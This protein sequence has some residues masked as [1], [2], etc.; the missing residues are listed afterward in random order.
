MKHL[1]KFRKYLS[2]ILPKDR[3]PIPIEDFSD[4]LLEYID[5]GISFTVIEFS[6]IDYKND[7][8]TP[9][10]GYFGFTKNKGQNLEFIT[11]GKYYTLLIEPCLQTSESN[12]I[13][14]Y[15]KYSLIELVRKCRYIKRSVDNIA[16]KLKNF[17]GINTMRKYS[18][19]LNAGD[20]NSD[21]YN[22]NRN[23]RMYFYSNV[24]NRNNEQFVETQRID[25]L[26]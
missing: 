3:E 20:F 2:S 15:K 18:I 1:N 13:E 23:N 25:F 10:G 9:T 8:Y 14:D 4:I 7:N 11:P 26:Y 22:Y 19:M 5:E 12:S 6:S 21:L 16:H 24:D 17:Y